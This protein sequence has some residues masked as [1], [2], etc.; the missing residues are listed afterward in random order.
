MTPAAL[1]TRLH[2][3]H[4]DLEAVQGNP[5]ALAVNW[6]IIASAIADLSQELKATAATP[7]GYRFFTLHAAQ[8]LEGSVQALQLTC[9]SDDEAEPANVI[10]LV[11]SAISGLCHT[12]HRCFLF[13]EE[14]E[15]AP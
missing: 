4:T 11:D 7:Q 14:I 1:H 15:V 8:V 12:L 5:L 9:N 13:D 10:Q 2:E 6:S 3:L